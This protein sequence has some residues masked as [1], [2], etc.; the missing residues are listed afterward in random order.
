[1]SALRKA[2]KRLSDALETLAA[3]VDRRAVRAL[4]E[5]DFKAI[6]AHLAAAEKAVLEAMSVE[7]D[8]DEDEDHGP[9]DR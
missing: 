6:E 1:M 7:Q 5:A 2:E 9:A 4:G 8:E 3:A